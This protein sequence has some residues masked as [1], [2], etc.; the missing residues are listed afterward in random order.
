[1][2]LSKFKEKYW[3][4]LAYSILAVLIAVAAWYFLKNERTHSWTEITSATDGKEITVKRRTV[5]VS[6]GGDISLATG[7]RPDKNI[8]H[9]SSIDGNDVDIT[10][11]S[12]RRDYRDTYP[13][14]P[15]YIDVL[16]DGKLPVV[17][18][19]VESKEKESCFV[20]YLYKYQEDRWIGTRID[21][22]FVGKVSNIYLDRP[23]NFPF[24]SV[25]DEDRKKSLKKVTIP[26]MFKEILTDGVYCR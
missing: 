15:I 21:K 7:R 20:Y 17:V 12:T 14:Q 19:I 2:D 26:R 8:I 5:L 9:F 24:V 10:W 22:R 18:S 13:E 3:N 16:E 6:G 1:M 25:T 4:H 11:A 23:N